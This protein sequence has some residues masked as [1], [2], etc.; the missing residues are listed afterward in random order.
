VRRRHRVPP[1]DDSDRSNH[2]D[3]DHPDGAVPGL[4]D[5]D[6]AGPAHDAVAVTVERG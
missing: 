6:A 3:G 4:L 5:G 2:P 1:S